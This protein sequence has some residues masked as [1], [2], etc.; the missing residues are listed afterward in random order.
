MACGGQVVGLGRQH[1]HKQFVEIQQKLNDRGVMVNERL[2]A[3]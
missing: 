1:E 3:T 2:E